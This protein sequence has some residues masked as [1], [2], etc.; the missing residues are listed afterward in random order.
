[1]LQIRDN[2]KSSQPFK[3][4]ALII[5]KSQNPKMATTKN[6]I[7][8]TSP[9]PVRPTNIIANAAYLSGIK[10]ALDDL[11]MTPRN[12]PESSTLKKE[13]KFTPICYVLENISPGVPKQN[14]SP[15]PYEEN[16]VFK[17]EPLFETIQHGSAQKACT[18][19]SNSILS[20]LLCGNATSKL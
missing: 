10:D 14:A 13:S 9:S 8:L 2:P 16:P 5:P 17:S 19:Q 7:D 1:M 3:T 12:N 18:S 6:T 15:L 20:S 11:D 4:V